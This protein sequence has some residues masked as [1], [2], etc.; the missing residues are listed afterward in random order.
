MAIL[1]NFLEKLRVG[2]A[3]AFA[4]LTIFP[5]LGLEPNEPDYVL[6]DEAVAQGWLEIKEINAAGS[7]N[8]I[9]VKN[10]GAIPVLILDG[11]ILSGAKQNRVVNATILIAA[12]TELKIPVS[13]VEQ[14]RWHYE[15]DRFMGSSHFSYANLRAQKSA[16]VAQSLRQTGSF[17]AD[18]LAIWDEVREKQCRMQAPSPTGAVDSL[19]E[20]HRALL[21]QYA[22][23]FR[24]VEG[25]IGTAVFING[26]F[27]CLDAF[28]SPTTLKKLFVK[29]VESYALDAL[30]Q[31]TPT[32]V[33]IT[34]DMLTQLLQRLNDAY[35]T[36]YPSIGQGEDLRIAAPGLTG[37]C[38]VFEGHLLHLALFSRSHDGNSLD[39]NSHNGHNAQ[40]YHPLARPS[41]RQRI[42]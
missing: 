26:R 24:T 32:P 3:Q 22:S 23:A 20:S 21:G 42:Y 9:L 4:N 10:H 8:E 33:Q 2:E 28:D 30:E 15:T 7:V 35:V 13:C 1:P 25:Q 27:I 31:P 37:S 39:H 36:S 38:L 5:L 12:H 41:W 16:Q 29:M 18:Q 17:A 19:Y 34:K 6:L 11:E 40:L 14:G